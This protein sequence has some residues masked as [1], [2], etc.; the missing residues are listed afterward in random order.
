MVRSLNRNENQ[1]TNPTCV[2]PDLVVL[3]RATVGPYVGRRKPARPTE[4]KGGVMGK[5]TRI[6]VHFRDDVAKME[7]SVVIRPKGKVKAVVFDDAAGFIALQ[8][9]KEDERRAPIAKV[10]VRPSD[11]TV[12]PVDIEVTDGPEGV[13]YLEDGVLKCWDPT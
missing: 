10:A 6:E 5:V 1:D 8:T 7:R 2:L 13:C 12:L 11:V 3:D 4:E 9:A